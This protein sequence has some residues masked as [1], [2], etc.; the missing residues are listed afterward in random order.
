MHSAPLDLRQTLQ[1]ARKARRLSQL[2]LSFRLGVSQ[3]HVSFV[4]SGRARPSRDLLVQWLDELDA[5]L[6]LR[7]DALLLAGY[8]PAYSAAALDA[9]VLHAATQAL[10]ALLATHDP[11]PA[12]V[13]DA[14]WQLVRINR[15]GL[16]FATQLGLA[17]DAAPT[18]ALN[19]LDLF[20][21]PDGF[22]RAMRPPSVRSRSSAC[23]PPSARRRTSRWRRCA[24]NTSA[25]PMHTPEPCCSA[26][27]ASRP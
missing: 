3:R 24:W 14:E 11:M 19:M 27:L 7:N 15:G 12:F 18:P 13:I 17:L 2:E 25:Q 5:P 4:E 22:T 21:H 16:W 9:P 6:V 20:A 8:A 10:E 26:R 1:Q 23:S